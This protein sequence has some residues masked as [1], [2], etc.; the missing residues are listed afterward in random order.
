M[1]GKQQINVKK[2]T[3]KA[4]QKSSK[5]G[6]GPGLKTQPLFPLGWVFSTVF[7]AWLGAYQVAQ[8]VSYA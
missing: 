5:N 1:E 6:H 3:N 4:A 7:S 2:S 8:C